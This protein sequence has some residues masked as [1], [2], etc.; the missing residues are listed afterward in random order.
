MRTES[1]GSTTAC[2]LA[3][4]HSLSSRQS[5]PLYWS[6]CMPRHWFEKTYASQ[7]LSLE[8]SRIDAHINRRRPEE[9]VNTSKDR[10]SA[11]PSLDNAPR[12]ESTHA[13]TAHKYYSMCSA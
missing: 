8:A 5:S 1:R 4:I 12:R 6:C 11:L 7:I 3:F 10:R 9:R 13:A 2:A